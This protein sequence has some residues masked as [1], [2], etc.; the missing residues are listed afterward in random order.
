MTMGLLKDRRPV[1]S[2]MLTICPGI[3]VDDR[4]TIVEVV[5]RYSGVSILI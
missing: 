1:V 5:P 3:V 2:A 4:K